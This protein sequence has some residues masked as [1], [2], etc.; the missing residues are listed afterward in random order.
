M[1][2]RKL[3]G[4]NIKASETDR[5]RRGSCAELKLITLIYFRHF[6]ID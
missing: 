4:Y 6:H 5:C 2:P 3:G 1:H